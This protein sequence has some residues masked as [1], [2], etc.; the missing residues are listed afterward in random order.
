MTK[1]REVKDAHSEAG[2]LQVGTL[3]TGGIN[4]LLGDRAA[5]VYTIRD[6]DSGTEKQVMASSAKALGE[7]FARGKLDP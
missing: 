4:P 7:R 1:Q 6:R 2:G 3:A 5:T